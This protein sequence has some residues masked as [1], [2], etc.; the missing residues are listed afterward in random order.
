MPD[1]HLRR[2]FRHGTLT[3][4]AVFE[5]V[6]RHNSYTRAAEELHMAQPTVSVQM[7]KLSDTVG[8]PLL[9]MIG[10][11]VHLTEAGRELHA[12]CQDI[13]DRI[14]DVETRLAGLRSASAGQLRLAVSTTGMHFAPRLL[15]QFAQQHVGMD[16]SLAVLNRQNLLQRLAANADDFYIF[17]NP[18]EDMDVVMHTLL[19]NPLEIYARA[20]H[21][22]AR[23]KRLRFADIAAE[24]FLMRE[25]GSGT[26]MVAE[27]LFAQHRL[28]PNVH[29]ELGSNEAIKQAILG[30]LGLSLLSR[31][32]IGPA[33]QHEGLVALDVQGL[34]VQRY[35]YLVYP[36]GRLLSP[37]AQ[38]FLDALRRPGALQGLDADLAAAEAKA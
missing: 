28:A 18:P 24:P 23:R 16:I 10:R 8:L 3:Q 25:A 17:S 9:E 21:P 4:L 2:Y 7:K 35:W 36:E 1:R 11:R 14:A 30:G 34:P 20:D 37:A 5:A 19:P 26:R 29:M 22:L 27:E 32:T 15:A 38:A 6:A 13:F 12:A 33:A 31:Q